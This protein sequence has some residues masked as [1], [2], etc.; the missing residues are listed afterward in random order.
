MAGIF[1]IILY[2]IEKLMTK[3]QENKCFYCKR[4]SK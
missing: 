3:S 4:E 2:F 1:L